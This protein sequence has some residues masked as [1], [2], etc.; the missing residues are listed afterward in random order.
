MDNTGELEDQYRYPLVAHSDT[1]DPECCGSIFPVFRENEADITCNECGAII[2][3]VPADQAVDALMEIG[4]SSRELHRNLP[5]LRTGE[6][7]PRLLRDLCVHLPT[8][9]E[10]K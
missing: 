3:T 5:P 4:A 8:L 6:H 9:R 10:R 1:G 7:L 2:K